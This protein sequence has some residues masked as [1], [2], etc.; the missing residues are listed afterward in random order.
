MDILL[1]SHVMSLYATR[2]VYLVG[3][4]YMA[5]LGG[6][7]RWLWRLWVPIRPEVTGAPRPWEP[8]GASV[9]HNFTCFYFS[10][11]CHCLQY[12]FIVVVTRYCCFS[13]DTRVA[14]TLVP[15]PGNLVQMAV[16]WHSVW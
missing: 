6:D 8:A 9:A 11:F 13:S 3:P 5:C 4:G 7:A 1:D 15:G 2:E 12:F 16:W 10:S 14:P